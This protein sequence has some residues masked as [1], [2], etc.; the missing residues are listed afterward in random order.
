MFEAID[1]ISRGGYTLFKFAESVGE[2]L[3]A[4][5]ACAGYGPS[6]S[7]AIVPDL[8][9]TIIPFLSR[10]YIGGIIEDGEDVL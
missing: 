7:T 10:L 2:I 9:L 4:F 6:C 3:N 8:V 5:L 1:D